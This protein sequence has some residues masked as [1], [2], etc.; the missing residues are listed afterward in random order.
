METPIQKAKLLVMGVLVLSASVLIVRW[1]II[2][3][4]ANEARIVKDEIQRRAEYCQGVVI[5][6]AGIEAGKDWTE[7]DRLA[8]PDHKRVFDKWCNN[9]TTGEMQ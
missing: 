3:V 4:M 2:D 1:L 7:I 6:R 8:H 5:W 9:S